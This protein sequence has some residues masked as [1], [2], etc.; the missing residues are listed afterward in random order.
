[1]VGALALAIVLAPSAAIVLIVLTRKPNPAAWLNLL[2]SVVSFAAAVPIPFIVGTA[3][4]MSIG[5]AT[6]AS[7]RSAPG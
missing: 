7:T 5:A 1:M 3:P 2:A 4:R 6:S